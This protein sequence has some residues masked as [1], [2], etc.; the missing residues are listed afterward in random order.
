[1]QSQVFNPIQI[2]AWLNP[3]P[4]A[5]DLYLLLRLLIAGSST[6]AFLRLF[7]ERFSALSGAVAYMLT[8][9]FVVFLGMPDISVCVI[10]PGLFYSLERTL[11]TPCARTS[12]CLAIFT[13]LILVGGMPEVSFLALVLGSLYALTRICLAE[14]L[15]RAQ[16]KR[17]VK[18]IVQSET[19]EELAAA[20]AAA[21]IPSESEVPAVKKVAGCAIGF[22]LGALLAAPMLLPFL[23]YMRA[24]FNAHDLPGYILPGCTFTP[25]ALLH[26]L[27]YIAPLAYGPLGRAALPA[28]ESYIGVLGYWGASALFLASVAVVASINRYMHG[29]RKTIDVLTLFCAIS[30]VLLIAKRFG[31]PLVQWIGLLPI[32]RLVIYWKY[33]EPLIGFFVA[34]LTGLGVHAVQSKG[35]S[36]RNLL[37]VFVTVACIIGALVVIDAGSVQAFKC[38]RLAIIGLFTA[39]STMLV[40]CLIIA[41]KPSRFRRLAPLMV[42]VIAAELSCNFIIPTFYKFS[43]FP[44]AR[45]NPYSGAPFIS[46]LKDKLLHHERIFGYDAV[47]PPNWSSA[48]EI[49]D[50]RDQDAMYP[51]RFLSFMQAF[52]YGLPV[53]NLVLTDHNLSTRLDGE[54]PAI[55]PCRSGD[56]WRVNRL[57]QLTSVQYVLG[58]LP[59]NL[60]E[61]TS[62]ATQFSSPVYDREVKIFGVAKVLPRAA[63]FYNAECTAT[64]E[65]A[66]KR[67]LE[68]TLDVFRSAVIESD[69]TLPAR[70]LPESAQS[71]EPAQ[72]IEFGPLQ[73]QIVAKPSR[74]AVLVLNDTFF[75]GWKCFVDEKAEP[76]LRANYLFRAVLLEPGL[77]RI[78]F[79]YEPE[80]LTI[81]LILAAVGALIIGGWL[82][83]RGNCSSL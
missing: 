19:A 61:S 69:Q 13:A 77:H 45:A 63:I 21:R 39:V 1:M 81:G 25:N 71:C 10:I 32:F 17:P 48:F 49:E 57:W 5:A 12:V 76:I 70:Q 23:E 72:I 42:A 67:L 62:L 40:L 75:P 53:P 46:F 50:I 6:Y 24:S 54:E 47:L 29:I 26:L 55:D 83:L 58:T 3:C 64:G 56:P 79:T 59:H 20:S 38:F 82:F 30:V 35:V 8:G 43:P 80:S 9:Y 16:V 7:A 66:L 65:E 33:G 60:S 4:R 37:F 68:P 11:Q 28:S 2:I 31:S 18:P 78:R 73:V 41:N 51:G 27:S 34:V 14:D 15:P 44:P 22:V 52:A 74:K 36:P